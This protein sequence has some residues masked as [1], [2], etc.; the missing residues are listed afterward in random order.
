[1]LI[2][3]FACSKQMMWKKDRG[4]P[5]RLV[6][7]V[8]IK[9]INGSELSLTQILARLTPVTSRNRV[10][11]RICFQKCTF[12]NF[13]RTGTFCWPT[14][15]TLTKSPPIYL[16]SMNRRIK[17]ISWDSL[18]PGDHFD[19]NFDENRQTSFFWCTPNQTTHNLLSQIM[20]FGRFRT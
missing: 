10:F 20:E 15:R 16:I 4:C 19:I 2:N 1:M 18:G 5:G 17:L 7:I 9:K 8:K 11:C 3:I 14:A 12:L 6:L 13:W